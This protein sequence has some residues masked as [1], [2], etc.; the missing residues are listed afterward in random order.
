MAPSSNNAPYCLLTS[1]KKLETF[2]EQFW[3]KC[4]KFTAFVADLGAKSMIT[5]LVSIQGD[6]QGNSN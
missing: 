5:E 3:R 4:P 2:N 1:C 6:L